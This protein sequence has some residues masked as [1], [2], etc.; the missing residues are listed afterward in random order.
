MNRKNNFQNTSHPR[1]F[2]KKPNRNKSMIYKNINNIL[3][4]PPIFFRL[5]HD[6]AAFV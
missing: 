4:F 1:E 3:T 5:P 6:P 2:V